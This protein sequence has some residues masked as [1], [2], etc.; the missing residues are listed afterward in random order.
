V[1]QVS[2]L[3]GTGI[4]A[5]W[6]AI[7]EHTAALEPG[8]ERQARR[9]EQARQWMWSLVEEGLRSSFRAHPEVSSQ[10]DALEQAVQNLEITPA[11]AARALLEAFR[12]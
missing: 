10:I 5:V 11:A 4:D 8:G 6:E 7:V 9:K 2:S 1:L 3:E 12:S